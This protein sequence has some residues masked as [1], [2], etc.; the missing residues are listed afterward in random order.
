MSA[1]EIKDTDIS[2]AENIL[3]NGMKFDDERV[4]FIANF[5]TLDLQSVPGSGKTTALLAKLV[6][7]DRYM[8]FNDDKGVVVISHTN[9]AVN[10]WKRKLGGFCPKLFSYPNFVGTIQS[11][12]NNYF[13]KPYMQIIYKIESFRVDDE[14]FSNNLLN[15][16]Y[17]IRYSNEYDKIATFF[18][19]RN[20]AKAK[21]IA[22]ETGEREKAVCERLIDE[23]IKKLYYNF[24]DEKFYVKGIKK[25]LISD[26]KNPKYQGL[27][28]I[29]D[30]V[31]RSGVISFHYAYVFSLKFL[32]LNPLVVKDLCRR[33]KFAFVDEMQDM[34]KLQYELLER[35][36]NNDDIV[37]QRVGDSNQS[38]YNES[39][40]KPAWS[41]RNLVLNISGS[42][43][44]TPK[45][46]K[47]VSCFSS[48][49]TKI[50]GL[51][52]RSVLM[53]HLIV[54]SNNQKDKVIDKYI[55]LYAEYE[56]CEMIPIVRDRHIGI[57][58]WVSTNRDDDKLTLSSFMGKC[59]IKNSEPTLQS[60]LFNLNKSKDIEIPEVCEC[61]KDAIVYVLKDNDVK[62]DDK[63][64]TKNQL[65]NA[66]RIEN[67]DIYNALKISLYKWSTEYIEIGCENILNDIEVYMSGLFKDNYGIELDSFGYLRF[68]DSIKI[69]EQSF[70]VDS[71]T[72][73]PIFGTIHSAKGQTHTSTLYIESYYDGKYESDIMLDVIS[74]IGN[75]EKLIVETNKK[76][77]S[78]ESE[79][80]DIESSGKVRGIKTREA[81]IKKLKKSIERIEDCSKMLYVGLSRPQY[82][83][84]MAIEEERYKKLTVNDSVWKV[85]NV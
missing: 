52:D 56:R 79:I 25:C 11:F 14:D 49:E 77:S 62:F 85:V 64:I 26:R 73:N 42:H 83:L 13:A 47:V 18:W 4:D 68:D 66:F 2:Y 75:T 33:F 12:A 34:D 65:F 20:I 71:N 53:P 61:I 60:E 82:F 29:F 30:S 41:D 50:N 51:N 10:E 16:Y 43:R 6:I 35:C 21:K 8:P 40:E 78:I 74:G 39:N 63:V 15:Q 48:T 76:I 7:L 72:Y 31:F 5:S 38:I 23:E 69:D 59:Q 24:N 57:V 36:F 32:D 81:T 3:I 19:G 45:I 46:A 27:K 17:K 37:Y 28:A 84:C 70:E 22:S 67:E 55:E 44:L 58:S 1:L 54:F 9:A 80:E